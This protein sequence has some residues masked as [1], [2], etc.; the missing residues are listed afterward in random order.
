MSAADVDKPGT[1]RR[2]VYTDDYQ[3]MSVS[4]D[5]LTPQ[6]SCR[7][8]LPRQSGI[9]LGKR[10]RPAMDDIRQLGHNAAYCYYR[11]SQLTV[12]DAVELIARATP[13]RWEVDD[14]AK[15]REETLDRY[16]ACRDDWRGAG[17]PTIC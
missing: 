8:I 13:Y 1:S 3:T 9:N 12:T 6:R 15:L 7:A 11:D 17:I 14:L 5:H 4:H 16:L 2:R 10:Y